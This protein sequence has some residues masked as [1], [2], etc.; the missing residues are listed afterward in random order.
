MRRSSLRA[1]CFDLDGTLFDDRQYARAGLIS[2]AAELQ[3]RTGV[4]LTAE[5][6]RAYFRNGHREA[7]FDVVLSAA[8][9][10]DDH[11]PALVRAYHDNEAS[12]VP[13]PD[14]AETLE[15]LGR[16]YAI[17]VVTGGTNGR[18]KLS[19]L[20]LDDYVDEVVVTAEREDSKRSPGP[21]VEIAERL[22]VTHESTVFV[23]DRP[24]L[25]FPQPNQLG[26]L[27]VRLMRGRYADTIARNAAAPD[28]AVESLSA[29]PAVVS[30]FDGR[31]EQL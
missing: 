22:R 27:T 24:P 19:R 12:L 6:L 21:F 31:P 23:G 14:A 17:G 29:L 16:D 5:F 3:R 18:E 8:G 2:A 13:Y 30:R 26:M 1:V 20:G 10:A 9:L 11:V 28:A 7:T 4:D 15:R 25:D